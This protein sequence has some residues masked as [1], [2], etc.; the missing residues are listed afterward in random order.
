MLYFLKNKSTFR[1][2]I[3]YKTFLF[4][5][6]GRSTYTKIVEINLVFRLNFARLVYTFSLG[7]GSKI[8]LFVQCNEIHI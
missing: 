1:W 7:F 8:S 3:L 6:Y 5:S 4:L 2:R